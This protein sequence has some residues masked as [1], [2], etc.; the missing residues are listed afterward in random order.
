MGVEDNFKNVFARF[1]L[2]I[3]HKNDFSYYKLKSTFYL[4]FIKKTIYSFII[5]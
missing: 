4:F 3:R 1:N 5:I 2:I